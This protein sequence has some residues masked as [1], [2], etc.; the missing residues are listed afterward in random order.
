MHH[1]LKKE[2]DEFL[3]LLVSLKMVLI[4]EFMKSFPYLW[5]HVKGSKCFSF[6]SVAFLPLTGLFGDQVYS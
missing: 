2:K 6:F 5:R 3:L 4:L 1:S